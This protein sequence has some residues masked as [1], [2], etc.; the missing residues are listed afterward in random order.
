MLLH[1]DNGTEVFWHFHLGY[2]EKHHY[3]ESEN[4]GNAILG[5]IS[6]MVI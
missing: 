1:F 4:L 6:V 5:Y 3:R 2:G